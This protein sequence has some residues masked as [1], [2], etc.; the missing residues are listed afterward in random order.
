MA[1]ANTDSIVA[2]DVNNMLRGLHRDNTDN[3]HTGDT[4]IT[5]LASFS[6]TG[7]TMGATGR[8]VIEAA[9]TVTGAAGA[10][11]IQLFFGATSIFTT[12]SLTG[13]GDWFIRAIISNTAT[14]AQRISTQAS[15]HSSTAIIADYITAAIDTTASVTIRCRVT[16]AD[17]GDT[18]TQTK[19]EIQVQQIS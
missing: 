9:G 10:K 12:T 3:S 5:D 17:A 15:T 1:F 4:N 14:G 11:T 8:L 6:M 2:N 18:V 19:Y 16:L 7:G 13:T